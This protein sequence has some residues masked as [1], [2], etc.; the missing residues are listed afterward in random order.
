[1]SLAPFY[2]GG[3]GKVDSN[4][5]PYAIS[6][7]AVELFLDEMK[8]GQT[9]GISVNGRKWQYRYNTRGR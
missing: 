9:G 2:T 6:G 7:Q 3:E 1:M 5:R 8:F 4:T